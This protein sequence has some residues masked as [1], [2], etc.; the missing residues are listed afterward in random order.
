M[1]SLILER[2]GYEVVEVASGREVLT[3]VGETRPDVILLELLLADI[4]GF[5]VLKWLKQNSETQHIP[6]IVVTALGDPGSQ[7]E[8]KALGAAAHITK[9]SASGQIE[10]AVA[11]AL[12]ANR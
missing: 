11:A 9:P 7:R 8:S 5:T 3:R 4:D 12:A 1:L 6:V 2:H 10:A